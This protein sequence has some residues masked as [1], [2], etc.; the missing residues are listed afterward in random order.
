MSLTVYSSK[1]VCHQSKISHYFKSFSLTLLFILVG[2]DFVFMGLHA[3]KSLGFLTDPNMSVT[4]KWGYPE[5]FQY[6]KAAFVAGCFFWLGS[7][8]KKPQLYSWAVI[9]LYVLLDDSL[10]IHEHLGYHAGTFLENAGISGGKTVG[11]LLVFAALG[12]IVFIPLFYYYFRSNHRDLKIMSQDLFMLFAAM[13][14]FG[15]GV[16][17]LHDM[18]E[19][20]TI[21]NGVLGLV[22]DGGE[23]LVMSVI[24]WYTWTMIQHDNFLA[25][26]GKRRK[27]QQG[28]SGKKIRQKDRAAI[29]S[30]AGERVKDPTAMAKK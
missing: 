25:N 23:M 4:Q 9:F 8:Y 16:D 10:E 26:A 7:K 12:F 28:V 29:S 1:Y 19:T 2:I 13:L 14:F 22:E 5:S 6:L 21:L 20:G 18:A 11:E 3:M 15:I 27:H 17:V 30:P 24:I